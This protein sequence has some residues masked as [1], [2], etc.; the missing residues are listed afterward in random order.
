MSNYKF[1]NVYYMMSFL[2]AGPQNDFSAFEMSMRLIE[3]KDTLCYVK[4]MRGRY[5]E[6]YKDDK[7]LY[8]SISVVYLNGVSEYDR[9]N[10]IYYYESRRFFNNMNINIFSNFVFYSPVTS[11]EYKFFLGEICD[12]LFHEAILCDGEQV[13]LLKVVNSTENI[14]S[15]ISASFFLRDAYQ[16]LYFHGMTLQ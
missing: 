5:I 2:Y 9:G 11:I 13:E 7:F 16:T 10:P 14:F 8:S 6:M 15:L 1:F 12:A 3:N 4:D